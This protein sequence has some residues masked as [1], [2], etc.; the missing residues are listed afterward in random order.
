MK[1]IAKYGNASLK[2]YSC[3]GNLDSK[4]LESQIW[5]ILSNIVDKSGKRLRGL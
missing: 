2:P 4:Y 5:I 3:L 1:A